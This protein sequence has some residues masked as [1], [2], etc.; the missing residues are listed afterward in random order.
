MF[1]LKITGGTVVDGTGADRFLADI[2]IK[3]GVIVEASAHATARVRASRARR[4]R[5]STP[6]GK[7]WPPGWW[8]CIRT[9]T[10]RPSGT[11]CPSR[12]AG[13]E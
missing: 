6:P 7:S 4:S 10:A 5:R 12:P 1:D 2:A 3:D 8:T 13:M 11:A 9:T